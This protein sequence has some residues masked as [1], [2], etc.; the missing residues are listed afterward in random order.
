MKQP[1]Y[2]KK[3]S[4]IQ[5]CKLRKNIYDLK[6]EARKWYKKWKMILCDASFK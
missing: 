4:D 6:Q 2:I 3:P 5:V 1:E